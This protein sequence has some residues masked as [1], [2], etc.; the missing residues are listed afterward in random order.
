MALPKLPETITI[1]G[2]TF[3]IEMEADPMSGE[4]LVDGETVGSYRRI[5]INS[6]LD[7][8][9]Q[10][11]TLI[12]EYIHGALYVAGVGNVLNDAVEE[13][14]AQTVEHAILQLLDQHGVTLSKLAAGRKK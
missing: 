9:R 5:R 4:D 13:I 14:I 3:R 6:N 10:W 2:E 12:H 8:E 7:M 1:L 11:G